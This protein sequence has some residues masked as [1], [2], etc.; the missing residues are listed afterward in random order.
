MT[1][2]EKI[3]T[4]GLGIHFE[5]L[6]NNPAYLFMKKHFD[7]QSLRPKTSTLQEK[8]ETHIAE[9]AVR[10][11][12]REIERFSAGAVSE[13]DIHAGISLED[14]DEINE[15]EQSLLE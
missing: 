15:H 4:Q 13:I 3:E 10:S 7:E 6:V 8:A 1:P 14:E 12:F 11:V 2:D 9:C 5:A